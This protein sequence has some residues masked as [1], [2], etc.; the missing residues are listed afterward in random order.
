MEW[1]QLYRMQEELDKY[2][3]EQRNLR[4]INVFEEKCLA[5]L[6]EVGELANETR[7]FKFWSNK[8][9]S[10]KGRILEEY[11]DGIHFI[12]SLGLE[13]GYRY[14]GG[15]KSKHRSTETGQFN[16]VFQTCT[17]FQQHP[18]PST[19]DELFASYLQLGSLLGF[20]R[21]D[22]QQAYMKKNEVNYTRQE[23]GY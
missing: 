5:L 13:K 15:D 11:V 9:R 8:R 22:I 1:E 10:G 23:E 2:I 17:N 3:E 14:S 16:T 4:E 21:E 20:T 18:S 19:Y 7:C 12:L 6:V